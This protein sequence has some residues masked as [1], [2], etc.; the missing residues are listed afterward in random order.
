[1]KKPKRLA[2]PRPELL[3]PPKH[4][5]DKMLPDMELVQEVCTKLQTS[6][7]GLVKILD[8]LRAIKPD[9]P[10][11][12]TF[13]NWIR[14][15]D[16]C[17]KLYS[18][19]RQLQADFFV[20]EAVKV[21]RTPMMTETSKE[22]TNSRGQPCHTRILSDNVER[23]KLIVYTLMKRAAQLNPKKYG[24]HMIHSGDA[25][26]PIKL[27]VEHIAGKRIEAGEDDSNVG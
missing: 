26:D 6:M 15:D 4:R 11:F 22:W 14:D 1:M 16:D 25:G 10:S 27:V 23:S 19:A 24:E 3:A 7:D 17:L 9:T 20:D 5:K 2:S 12:P 13:Y 8:D 18:H 21:A